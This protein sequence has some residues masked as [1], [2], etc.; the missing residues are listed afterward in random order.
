MANTQAVTSIYSNKKFWYFFL[1]GGIKAV[2][3]VDAFQA[4]IMF[5]SLLTIVIKVQSWPKTFLHH[6]D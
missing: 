1:Q 5:G 6:N 4:I 3:W 2:V